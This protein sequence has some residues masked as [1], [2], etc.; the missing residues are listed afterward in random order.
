M[1]ASAS[2]SII[3]RL[4]MHPLDALRIQQQFSSKT[5]LFTTAKLMQSQSIKLFYRGLGISL[6]STPAT[7]LYLM[8]YDRLKHLASSSSFFG[9]DSCLTVPC[10]A[11]GSEIF[12]GLLYVPIEVI[13]SNLVVSKKNTNTFGMISKL[14]KENGIPA[15]YKGYFISLAVFIPQSVTYFGFYE[16]LKSRFITNDSHFVDYMA[17]SAISGA[18]A[19][20]V[21]NPLDIVK[22]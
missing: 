18:T 5:S 21:G 9:N 22:V 16:F 8:T 4:I 13:K 15:F 1:K 10:A 14:Y 11:L 7:S 12:S 20:C 6:L 17:C 3:T 19:A 2:A